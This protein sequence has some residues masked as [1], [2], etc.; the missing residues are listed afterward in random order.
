MSKFKREI[1]YEV[2]KWAD[3][4]LAVTPHEVKELIRLSDKVHMSRLEHR[5]GPLE[6]AVVESDWPEYEVVWKMIEDRMSKK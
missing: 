2:F 1:R 3:L 6:C 5:K 4:V